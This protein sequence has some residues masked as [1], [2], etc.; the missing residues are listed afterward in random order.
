MTGIYSVLDFIFRKEDPRWLALVAVLVE[1]RTLRWCSRECLRERH[2]HM[3]GLDHGLGDYTD[4]KPGVL[5]APRVLM[6]IRKFLASTHTR[7][8]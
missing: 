8:C 7:I 4:V 5:F 2:R 6:R 3:V 1:S